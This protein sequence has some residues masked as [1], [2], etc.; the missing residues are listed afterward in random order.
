M[1]L[2]PGRESYKAPTPALRPPRLPFAWSLVA[3][4]GRAARCPSGAGA[5]SQVGVVDTP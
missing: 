2:V 1:S 3:V 5:G 4:P